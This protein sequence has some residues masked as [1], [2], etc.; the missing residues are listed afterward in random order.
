VV[1]KEKIVP[2]LLPREKGDAQ[3]SQPRI[4]CTLEYLSSG[5]SKEHTAILARADAKPI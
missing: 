1:G 2:E 3:P 5:F 4:Y